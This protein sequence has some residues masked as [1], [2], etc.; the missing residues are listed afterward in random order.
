M[1]GGTESK[2][3][4]RVQGDFMVMCVECVRVRVNAY[5]IPPSLHA[6]AYACACA[7]AY[8][9]TYTY[10]AYAYAYPYLTDTHTHTHTHTHTDTD[11]DIQLTHAHLI[12]PPPLRQPLMPAHER[13]PQN[14][15]GLHG[16][17]TPHR[18]LPP[19]P[20]PHGL[21]ITEHWARA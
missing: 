16:E 15:E 10:A 12:M 13:Q 20:R 5:N 4:R 3:G 1:E 7:Y 17:I 11:T 18:H 8:T 21:K 2:K 14:P 6:Y 9:Y 19:P